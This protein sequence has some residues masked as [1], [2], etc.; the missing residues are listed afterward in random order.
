MIW[1]ADL[2]EGRIFAGD[3]EAGAVVIT[4]NTS[5]ETYNVKS[6]N[7][8]TYH[9]DTVGAIFN[10][11]DTRTFTD[12]AV[13]WDFMLRYERELS[14]RFSAYT[15]EKWESD[16]RS[17]YTQRTSTDVGGKYYFSKTEGNKIVTDLGYRYSDLLQDQAH[18]YGSYLR[19]YAEWQKAIDDKTCFKIWV[20]Y[21]PSL[22]F[23]NNYLLNYEES[24]SVVLS[25]LL[26]LKISYLTRYQQGVPNVAYNTD[27]T[28]T[29]ALVAKF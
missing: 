9:S 21:L 20:E 27:T 10:Y 17:G 29:A 19:L 18:T 11:V 25:K 14:A 12:R 23:N 3:E 1:A 26:S 5:A 24:L 6:D 4:G 7:A 8:F 2:A 13:F 28:T 16:E 15:D 22:N